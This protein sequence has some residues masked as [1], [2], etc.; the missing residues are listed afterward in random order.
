MPD[1][2]QAEAKL[3][4]VFGFPSFRPGQADIVGTGACRQGRARRD[5]DRRRQVAVL[6]AAGAGARRADRGGVAAD[7]ADAQSGG[8]ALQGYGIAA[9]ASIRPTS[10]PRK[11]ARCCDALGAGELRLLY[12]A[13]ERLALPDTLALLARG[14]RLAARRRRGAL[15]LAMGARFPARN[16]CNARQRRG[17][18]RRRAD[19]RAARPPPT[20]AT[21]GDIL[22]R[23]FTRAPRRVRARLRPART[24]G[25]P[26]RPKSNAA[27]QLVDFVGAHKGE[28][29]IVYCST[30]KQ[31]EELAER[32]SGKGVHALPYHAGMDSGRALAPPGPL[33]AG[34]RPRHG[35]RRSPSAWASTSPT[36][37]SSPTPTC[38]KASKPITRRSAA[39][40]ATVCP[41]TR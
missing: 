26:C 1:L 20:R 25:S 29:G 18:A 16:I 5:A 23:L 4:E 32:L 41:P 11:R 35:A 10:R 36:C 38:R 7:R 39:P 6:S 30:R 27:R 24:C 8:A 14:R 19:H 21:R 31:T 15:R 2:A 28:S 34:G 9:A 22:D 37:A 3:R 40:A 12:V 17:R 13:P 33:P